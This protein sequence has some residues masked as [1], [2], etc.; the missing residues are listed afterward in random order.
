MMAPRFIA[1]ALGLLAFSVSILGGLWTGNP[2]G[3]ILSRAVGAMALFTVIGL[4]IGWSVALVL[5]EHAAQR[6]AQLFGSDH[7]DQA[8]PDETKDRN[9]STHGD[10]QP[11]GT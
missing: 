9:T 4:V 7:P 10:P 2:V 8:Q 3:V 11:M 1:A 6:E 5:R